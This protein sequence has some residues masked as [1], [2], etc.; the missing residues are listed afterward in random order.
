MRS[1]AV[2][3]ALW[4]PALVFGSIKGGE[5]VLVE[6]GA[7]RAVI[8]VCDEAPPSARRAV[9]ELCDYIEKISGARLDVLASVP[10]PR[11]LGWGG[12]RH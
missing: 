3:T 8:V 10:E 12:T 6:G 7:S 1:F 2:A 4:L 9:G 5:L 11:D